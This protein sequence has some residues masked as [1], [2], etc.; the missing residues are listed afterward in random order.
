MGF[1]ETLA[2]YYKKADTAAHGYLPGGV[3]P[4]EYKVQVAQSQKPLSSYGGTPYKES[5]TMAVEV[6]TGRI[7]REA[8]LN[9]GTANLEDH[10]FIKDASGKWVDVG[11]YNPALKAAITTQAI[12]QAPPRMT[13]NSI[14]KLISQMIPTKSDFVRLKKDVVAIPKK[15]GSDFN[16]FTNA[17]ISESLST[18]KL[19]YLTRGTEI[20]TSSMPSSAWTPKPTEI[21][22]PQSSVNAPSALPLSS[23]LFESGITE[24]GALKV[25]G[26]IP[27]VALAKKVLAGYS[28]SERANQ[29]K[30]T[31]QVNE[32]IFYEGRMKQIEGERKVS[33]AYDVATSLIKPIASQIYSTQKEVD[34]T[35]A[36]I[37]KII[38]SFDKYQQ[39]IISTTNEEFKA[40]QAIIIEDAIAKQRGPGSIAWSKYV[41]KLIGEGMT[42]EKA[43]KYLNDRQANLKSQGAT[44][45]GIR[46]NMVGDILFLKLKV[47]WAD[48]LIPI[49]ERPL[50]TLKNLTLMGAVG[51]A[52]AG[53]MVLYPPSALVI[54]GALAALLIPSVALTSLNIAATPTVFRGEK[55][56]NL[57]SSLIAGGIGAKLGGYAFGRM[58]GQPVQINPKLKYSKVKEVANLTT[59]QTIEVKNALLPEEWSIIENARASGIRF[60]IASVTNTKTK[61]IIRWLFVEVGRF[62]RKTTLVE[63]GGREIYGFA[64]NSKGELVQKIFATVVEGKHPISEITLM[65][66]DPIV[67]STLPKTGNFIRRTLSG[68]TF[69][70]EQF[71]GTEL[72]S[73]TVEKPWGTE[74]AKITTTYGNAKHPT[75]R[76][77]EMWQSIKSTWELGVNTLLRRKVFTVKGQKNVDALFK[78]LTTK[79][80]ARIARLNIPR[81]SKIIAIEM[82]PKGREATTLFEYSTSALYGQK[83]TTGRVA[84]K[85]PLDAHVSN[86]LNLGKNSIVYS[87]GKTLKVFEVGQI[88]TL[89]QFRDLAIFVETGASFTFSKVKTT[90]VKPFAQLAPTD[91]GL[92]RSIFNTLKIKFTPSNLKEFIRSV[93]SK[94]ELVVHNGEVLTGMKQLQ[95]IYAGQGTYELTQ[96]NVMS[97]FLTPE[98]LS[99]FVSPT[100]G[101]AFRPA[102]GLPG[103]LI[104]ATA[105]SLF[106]PVYASPQTSVLSPI[107]AL[108]VPSQSKF[109]LNLALQGVSISEQ[110]LQ[111]DKLQFKEAQPQPQPSASKSRLSQQQ[112]QQQVQELAQGQIPI[113]EITYRR[114]P[115][116]AKTP[117]TT[118]LLPSFQ[119]GKKKEVRREIK[120]IKK[121]KQKFRRF[122][123]ETQL[124]FRLVAPRVRKPLSKLTGFELIR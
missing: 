14:A 110:V 19:P 113:T 104:Q 4:Q 99:K 17:T 92:L 80:R 119:F 32:Q 94:K 38:A 84:F 107:S 97:S 71:R 11:V 18:N 124:A 108:L 88:L 16:V 106:A 102:S 59:K 41:S 30:L 82:I 64:R 75:T 56:F 63:G 69:K 3:T 89:Q 117:M 90:P 46:E 120:K 91:I 114:P 15:V 22:V 47:Q 40:R 115:P 116:P 8:G 44:D 20:T 7:A 21:V 1:A 50:E 35:N 26:Y 23:A 54:K 87:Q 57:T 9:T 101:L 68:T 45:K 77:G 122:P 83:V 62:R 6:G 76:V 33:N 67:I 78:D 105:G 65:L 66:Q 29:D 34:A 96:S 95:S 70:V 27:T 58:M 100:G 39:E 10:H 24:R 48:A 43:E 85:I 98:G 5:K 49:R 53:A 118:F 112:L 31:A 121:K 25:L 93:A 111:K 81:G 86:L 37:T 103:Q 36:E 55:I 2:A 13:V 74:L 28:P 61:E 73:K 51:A 72:I 123:T 109:Q 79:Y 42:L 52:T 12:S 60:Y